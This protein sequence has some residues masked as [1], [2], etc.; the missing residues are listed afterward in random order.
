M[1]EKPRRNMLKYLL[2]S[3]NWVF[4]Q[5]RSVFAGRLYRAK[6]VKVL[7]S[8]EPH[9]RASNTAA[10]RT[11]ILYSC[12]RVHINYWQTKS[13]YKTKKK[14]T[15]A[16]RR[17]STSSKGEAKFQVV[18]CRWVRR[19]ISHRISIWSIRS[20][21][22][23]KWCALI[24]FNWFTRHESSGDRRKE[25]GTNGIPVYSCDDKRHCRYN[26]HLCSTLVSGECR[27]DGSDK[28]IMCKT[29]FRFTAA[30]N[31]RFINSVSSVLDIHKAW[32]LGMNWTVREH[33]SFS[34]L[35]FAF[36]IYLSLLLAL[37]ANHKVSRS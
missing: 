28:K 17:T 2:H 35:H 5:H 33:F 29:L 30:I 36:Y 8:F 24:A 21:M 3:R 19:I 37:S 26:R 12:W 32:T 13:L 10:C 16:Q 1:H 11:H 25:E 27:V 22:N 23:G 4:V 14:T 9:L 34:L 18:M 20:A 15:S 31:L 7:I 6:R